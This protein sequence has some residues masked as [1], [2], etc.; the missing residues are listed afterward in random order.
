MYFVA[1]AVA[2]N[3]FSRFSQ[4]GREWLN[5]TILALFASLVP[6]IL[7]AAQYSTFFSTGYTLSWFPGIASIWLFPVIVY[8]AVTVIISRKIY[9]ETA[10]PYIG[11]VI[12]AAVVTMISV[13]NTLTM[14]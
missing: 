1:S 14:G 7:V 13:S 5:T 3:C 2:A 9:R 4:L 11:G 12:N 8:L 6:C 10:N